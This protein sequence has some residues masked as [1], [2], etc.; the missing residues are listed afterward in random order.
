MSIDQ[1]RPLAFRTK[2]HDVQ[3]IAI[4]EAITMEISDMNKVWRFAMF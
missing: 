2:K 4:N 1:S 3:Q